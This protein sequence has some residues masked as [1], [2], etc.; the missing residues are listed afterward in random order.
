[1]RKILIIACLIAPLAACAPQK[2][3][4]PS[5]LREQTADATARL[6]SDAKAVAEGVKEGWD[7]NRPLDINSA[8]KDQLLHLPGISNERADRIIAGRPWRDVHEL[9]NKRVLSQQE[10]ERIEDQVTAK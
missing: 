1:M 3:Q 5:D 6:K 8:S 4:S 9:V 10:Y 2:Q 7:R